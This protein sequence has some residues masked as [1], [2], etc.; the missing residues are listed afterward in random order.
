MAYAVD[1][2]ELSGRMA[3]QVHQIL[4]GAK[5]AELP[6]YQATKFALLLNMKAAR[7]QEFTFPPSLLGRAD[8]LID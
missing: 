5:P 1:Q 7:A 8:E 3:D 2:L 4:G 6:V